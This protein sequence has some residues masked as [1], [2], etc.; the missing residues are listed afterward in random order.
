V[1]GDADDDARLRTR[2]RGAL[3]GT[4]FARWF[5]VGVANTLFSLGIYQVAVLV[6]PYPAAYTL[7]FVSGI[8]TAAWGQS[9]FAFGTRLH[10]ASLIRF[11]AVYLANYAAGLALL[12]LLIDYFGLHKAIAP[13]IVLTL[14][15]PLSFIA[16]R[17]ALR[18]K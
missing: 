18:D 3:W 13:F 5:W 6:M 7:A 16:S 4:Q 14:Q 2:L 8:L 15:I 9:R 17:L 12:A 1:S 11:T 10:T